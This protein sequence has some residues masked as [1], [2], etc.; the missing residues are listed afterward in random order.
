MISRDH[1]RLLSPIAVAQTLGEWIIWPSVTKPFDCSVVM[2]RSKKTVEHFAFACRPF[3]CG[4]LEE[5]SVGHFDYL[6]LSQ[7]FDHAVVSS[8]LIDGWH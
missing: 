7:Y 1:G 3:D 4:G 6:F 2:N 5:A 8:S